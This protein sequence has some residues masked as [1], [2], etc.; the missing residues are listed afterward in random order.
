MHLIHNGASTRNILHLAN[1]HRTFDLFLWADRCSEVHLKTSSQRLRSLFKESF[2]ADFVW[3]LPEMISSFVLCTTQSHF[4]HFI[5]N[6]SRLVE[7]HGDQLTTVLNWFDL[8]CVPRRY[9]LPWR[10]ESWQS[11]LSR[12]LL[13]RWA[14]SWRQPS[15]AHSRLQLPQALPTLIVHAPYFGNSQH[16]I[17]ILNTLAV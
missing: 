1:W 13:L 16:F 12:W 4:I 8:L 10:S 7:E 17:S 11:M 15:F 2:I 14:L 5:F 9:L 6:P 3:V